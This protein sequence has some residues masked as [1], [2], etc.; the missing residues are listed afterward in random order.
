[1]KIRESA[2]CTFCRSQDETIEYL[3]WGCQFTSNFILDLEHR[4]F[5]TQFMFTKQDIFFGYKLISRH[6]FNFWILHLKYYIFCKKMEEEVPVLNE[7]INKFRFV[8]QV[9]KRID[10]SYVKSKM[11]YG[12]LYIAFSKCHFLSEED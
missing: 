12:S 5:G 11:S 7:F 10:K 8:L 9:E 1:M 6:P 3:F 4:I 2:N